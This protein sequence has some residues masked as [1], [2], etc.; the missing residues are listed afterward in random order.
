M[1]VD[2]QHY[3]LDYEFL[4]AVLKVSVSL[5]G[6]GVHLSITIRA[7]ASIAG[8]F[9]CIEAMHLILLLPPF[10]ASKIKYLKG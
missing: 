7:L 9:L 5:L 4:M 3:L 1:R 10:V 8:V 2:F 6:L